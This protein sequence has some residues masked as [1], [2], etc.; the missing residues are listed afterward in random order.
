[1]QSVLSRIWTRVAVSISYDDNHYTII[2]LNISY[3]DNHYTIIQS[4]ISSLFAHLCYIA[5]YTNMAMC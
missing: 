5:I 2:Q 3:D 1:M 4:N